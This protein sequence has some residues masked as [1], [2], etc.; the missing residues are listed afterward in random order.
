MS[1]VSGDTGVSTPSAKQLPPQPRR[2]S[3]G[4]VSI[5]SQNTNPQTVISG[6]TQQTNAATQQVQ[7]QVMQQPPTSLPAQTAGQHQQQNVLQHQGG[8][9]HTS[10]QDLQMSMQATSQQQLQQQQFSQTFSPQMS[11]HQNIPYNPNTTSQPPPVSQVPGQVLQQIPPQP[12]FQHQQQATNQQQQN[13]IISPQQ[14]LDPQQNVIISPQQQQLGQQQVIMQPQILQPQQQQYQQQIQQPI[15][16]LQTPM[17]YS[18]NLSAQTSVINN[19]NNNLP[20]AQSTTT[21]SPSKSS[22]KKGRFRVVKGAATAAS[23]NEAKG[24][25]ALLSDTVSVASSGGAASVADS[26]TVSTVKKGRFLVKKAA[27][28]AAAATSASS[29]NNDKKSSPE[30]S[31]NVKVA[32]NITNANASGGKASEPTVTAE[33]EAKGGDNQNKTTST[34]ATMTAPATAKPTDTISHVAAAG[35]AVEVTT[36]KKGRFLVKTGAASTPN[37]SALVSKSLPSAKSTTD[38]TGMGDQSAKDPE[39]RANAPKEAP[40]TEQNNDN[41]TGTATGVDRPNAASTTKKKGRFVIKTG[42][43]AVTSSPSAPALSTPAL[44]IE[45]TQQQTG[46]GNIQF[47]QPPPAIPQIPNYIATNIPISIAGDPTYSLIDMNG[48]VVVVSNVALPMT[49]Q[50]QHQHP[51]QPMPAAQPPIQPQFV[52]PPVQNTAVPNNV[53]QQLQ[54]IS[55]QPSNLNAPEPPPTHPSIPRP[56]ILAD[57]RAESVSSV[58]KTI[59][60]RTAGSS[61]S[62][63]SMGRKAGKNGRMIGAGGVGKVLHYLDTLRSEVVEADRSMA[64]LQS[65]N[66][67]LVSNLLLCFEICSASLCMGLTLL[68]RTYLL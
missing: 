15:A 36:K 6:I 4:L 10:Q 41:N 33:V 20:A 58:V 5:D 63:W 60:N 7:Q 50:V 18:A 12:L 51:I 54:Q 22:I 31:D 68:L 65:D 17:L 47:A 61:G 30:S 57:E 16:M 2:P 29:A 43:G 1:E 39:Q 40:I 45:G 25:A 23:N 28:P 48:Q 44:V 14:Q 52:S 27:V 34:D 66:R 3:L 19:T 8:N 42:G 62:N 59:P 32:N 9:Q 67:I 38:V 37:L 35:K 64:S 26:S 24:G 53:G 49:Q 13:V 11:P 55:S 46:A 56:R 21:N